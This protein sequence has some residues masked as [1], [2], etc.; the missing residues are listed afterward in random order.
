MRLGTPRSILKSQTQQEKDKLFTQHRSLL[1]SM[2]KK[3]CGGGK[4]KGRWN[5]PGDEFA[6]GLIGLTGVGDNEGLRD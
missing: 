1:R 3:S 4:H 2:E 6:L 5:L